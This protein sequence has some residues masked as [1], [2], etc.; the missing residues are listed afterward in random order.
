MPDDPHPPPLILVLGMHRS[1]T[2]LLANVL[3]TLGAYM[4][5]AFLEPDDA[6]AAGYWEHLHVVAAHDRMLEA[7]GRAWGTRAAAL[8][9]P[10][11]W[12]RDDKVA[13]PRG[14]LARVLSVELAAA[15]ELGKPLA[16]KDPRL[17]RMLPLWW[18][19][20]AGWPAASRPEVRLLYSVRGPDA[21]ARSLGKRDTLPPDLSRLLWVEHYAEALLDGNGGV[22]AVVYDDWFDAPERALAPVLRA[23]GDSVSTAAALDRVR[24]LIRGDFRHH[25]GETPSAGLPAALDAGLRAWARQ[26]TRPA[27]LDAAVARYEEDRELFAPWTDRPLAHDPLVD[28]RDRDLK[29]SRLRGDLTAREGELLQYKDAYECARAAYEAEAAARAEL[30]DGYNDMRAAY[31]A[32]AAAR[33]QIQAGYDEMQAAYQAEARAREARDEQLQQA[34]AR[35]QDELR[36]LAGSRVWRNLER[37]G[38]RSGAPQDV[39]GDLGAA[40]DRLLGLHKTPRYGLF[41]V[42]RRLLGRAP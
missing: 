16:I 3:H 33:Q 18:D 23:L 39:P 8:P 14:E 35:V 2:S 40:L 31:E 32:E 11:A 7:I 5:E 30:H 34:A 6:N 38:R 10:A 20:I 26:G 36:G 42:L 19:L 13:Q 37:L 24:P 1:G 9:Y 22:G 15:A 27:E 41:V 25:A 28:I 12:W 4:G 17:C 21:V 29:L